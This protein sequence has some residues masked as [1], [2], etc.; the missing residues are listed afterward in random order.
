MSAKSVHVRNSLQILAPESL[1]A[2][3]KAAAAHELTTTSE[4]TR[5]ALIAQLRI[6]GFDPSSKASERDTDS[7]LT[8][9]APAVA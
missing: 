9:T 8:E 5:R 6:D 4:Y 7:V 2:A 1:T 3:I